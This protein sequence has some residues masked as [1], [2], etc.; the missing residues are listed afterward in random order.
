MQI[1]NT[2]ENPL[3]NVSHDLRQPNKKKESMIAKWLIKGGFVK[4]ERG[5]DIFCIIVFII[6]IV[7]A[8]V[9][10]YFNYHNV[11]KTRSLPNPEAFQF[12]GS[13]VKTTPKK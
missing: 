4:N 11:N 6:C 2:D 5:A 10:F 12:K 13:N 7:A 1:E 9:L 3:T 8:V